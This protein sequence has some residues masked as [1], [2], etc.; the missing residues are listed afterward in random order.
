MRSE[1]SFKK[2]RHEGLSAIPLN[3]AEPSRAEQG[4]RTLLSREAIEP[5]VQS[6]NQRMLRVMSMPHPTSEGR[7]EIEEGEIFNYLK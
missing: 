2:L 1:T 3:Q 6:S 4:N 7:D 5:R